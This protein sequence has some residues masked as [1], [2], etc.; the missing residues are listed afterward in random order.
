MIN[1]YPLRWPDGWPRTDDGDQR[2]HLAGWNQLGAGRASLLAQ[3]SRMQ[4]ELR[5]LGATNIVLSTNHPV[6]RD[7]GLTNAVRRIEDPGAAVY[8]TLELDG[9]QMVLAQDL[10]LRL[11]DN[12]RSLA[13]AVE[14]M[15]QMKRHGGDRM[16]AKAFDGFVALPGPDRT[17]WE[18]LGVEANAAPDVI[19]AAYR[20]LIRENHPDAGGRQ[21]DAQEIND[22]YAAA[23]RLQSH[24]RQDSVRP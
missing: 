24:S 17:C 10:Y 16:A 2:H 19:R 4:D 3:I 18:I 15:R 20:R 13:M 6:R 8:F 1:S 5:L 14:G 9:R 12:I 21:E 22:A 7:G 11:D 23:Q